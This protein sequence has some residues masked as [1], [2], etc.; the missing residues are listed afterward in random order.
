MKQLKEFN[1]KTQVALREQNK[2]FNFMK[3]TESKA[4][5]NMSSNYMYQN[6]L[7]EEKALL[8]ASIETDFNRNQ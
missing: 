5:K 4:I 3:E 7:K 2:H 1:I 8:L 6:Q